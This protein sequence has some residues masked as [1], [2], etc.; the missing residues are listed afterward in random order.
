M[1]TLPTK[2]TQNN[3]GTGSRTGLGMEPGPQ[4]SLG[5]DQTT[6]DEGTILTDKA[7]VQIDDARKQAPTTS[8]DG[9]LGNQPAWYDGA[10]IMARSRQEQ[11]NG[12]DDVTSI[13]GLSERSVFRSVT[14]TCYT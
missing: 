7:I 9:R 13:G 3:T 8:L 12:R 5:G 1:T 10:M 14:S 4:L 11:E 2:V 6:T